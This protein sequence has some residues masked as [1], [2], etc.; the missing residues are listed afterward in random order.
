MDGLC[1]KRMGT[2]RKDL[3]PPCK[4]CAEKTPGCHDSCNRYGAWQVQNERKRAWERQHNQA[5]PY[6]P[7]EMRRR[8]NYG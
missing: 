7:Y 6:D 2:R 4:D 3:L 1:E 8:K 5:A